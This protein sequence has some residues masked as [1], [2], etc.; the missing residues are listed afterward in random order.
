MHQLTTAGFPRREHN[1]WISSV[2]S[3]QTATLE[4]V[5]GRST[6][7]AVR[8]MDSTVGVPVTATCDGLPD[9][10]TCSYD[11]NNQTVT[12]TPTESTPAGTYPVRC[13]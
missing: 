11:G 9:G 2:E 7:L 10:A 3:F 13:G 8:L 6:P 1:A 4:V 12:I 5:P